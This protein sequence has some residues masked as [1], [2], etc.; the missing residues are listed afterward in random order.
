[1]LGEMEYLP[2]FDVILMNLCGS[3]EGLAAA[4]RHSDSWAG[5]AFGRACVGVPPPYDPEP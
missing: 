2:E 1:M 5:P 4:A 3:S